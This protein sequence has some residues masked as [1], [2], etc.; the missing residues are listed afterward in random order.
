MKPLHL[1]NPTLE[2]RDLRLV[3]AVARAGGLAAAADELC[4]TGSALS[5]HLRALEE[6]LGA[7][8]FDRVGRRVVLN[9]HGAR[10]VALADRLLPELVA[11]EEALRAPRASA[12]P[13]RIT[14][15]CYTVYPWLPELLARLGRELPGTSC[16][17]ITDATR[18]AVPAVLDGEVDAAVAPNVARDDRLQIRPAFDEEIVVVMRPDDPLTARAAVSPAAL[19]G[20]VVYAHPGSRE[21]FEWFRNALGRAAASLRQLTT[22]PLTEAILE[23]V[24]GGVGVAI[25]GSWTVARDVRRGE[26]VTRPLRPRV[27]RRL[28]VITSRQRGR[29]PRA[30]LLAAVLHDAATR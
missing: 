30:D 28:S 14:M 7:P 11:A 27:S 24:R 20:R 13:F 1:P 23:L 25:L 18:R 17:V 3:V 8:L 5:H 22:V 9:A 15:G 2:V 12:A 6:R 26:L 19:D 29:D 10:L 16:E 4:L 21:H